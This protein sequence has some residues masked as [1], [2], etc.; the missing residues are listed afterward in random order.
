MSMKLCQ[1]IRREYLPDSEVRISCQQS[2]QDHPVN[3]QD[4]TMLISAIVETSSV[5]EHLLNTLRL[6]VS[7]LH[8]DSQSEISIALYPPI[9]D[10]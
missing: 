5:H 10:I 1:P 3:D 9:S 4:C 2:V 7:N 8:P 6:L